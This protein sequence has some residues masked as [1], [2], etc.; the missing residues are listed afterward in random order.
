MGYARYSQLIQMKIDELQQIAA[1]N[2]LKIGKDVQFNEMGL[3][4]LVAMVAD[5]HDQRWVLRI[6]RRHGLKS[7]I[8][9]EKRILEFVSDHLSVAVPQWV[10]VD[11]TLIAYRRL[12]GEPV[13]TIDPQTYEVR[14]NIDQ[15][16]DHFV[17][18]LADLILEMQD[19]PI[20]AA[21]KAQI[22]V[23]S[24]AQVR[25][26]MSDCIDNVKQE[27]KVNSQLES[28]WRQWLDSDDYW[29]DFCAFVHGDLYAGHTLSNRKGEISG[30]I[31]WSEAHVGDPSVDFTGQLAAFGE[32]GLHQLIAAY[33]AKGGHVWARMT[34]H[35][36]E[37]HSTMALRYAEFALKNQ[38]SEHIEAARQQL[39]QD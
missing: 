9:Y 19:I 16:E 2:G 28:R 33:E 12:E 7:Q 32:H 14:W 38:L 15:D 18:S 34:E 3:D 5:Q 26:D 4:F 1:Q 22:K 23:R 36:V 10:I 11:E 25:K 17:P 21:E 24:I 37:R 8:L 31:D 20:D 35:I 27:I 39:E 29:P 6:P 13:I 30:V